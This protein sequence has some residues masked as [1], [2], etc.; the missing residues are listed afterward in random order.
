MSRIR[1]HHRRLVAAGA[2]ALGMGLVVTAP[3]ASAAFVYE[4]FDVGGTS[5]AA[6]AGTAGATSSGWAAGSTWAATGPSGTTSAYVSPGLAFGSGATTLVN[7]LLATGFPYDAHTSPL[8]NTSHLARFLKQAHGLRRAG[9]AA[10]DMAYVA[11]GRL[12]GYWEFKINAW[13]VAAGI[14]LV[15]EA[16]GLVTLMD[17]RTLGFGRQM[18]VVASNGHIHDD[19]LAVIRQT[20]HIAG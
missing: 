11:A 7:S 12:D 15:R 17:G 13:D 6:I 16:G 1:P 19:M 2:V 9:S 8:D 5:G 4:G 14:L 3:H 18:N 10:L 20:A